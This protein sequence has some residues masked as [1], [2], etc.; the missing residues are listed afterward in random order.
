VG[1][2]R[3]VEM[4]L[5][6]MGWELG[7]DGWREPLNAEAPFVATAHIFPLGERKYRLAKV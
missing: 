5:N 3:Q 7:I 2:R 4:M 6:G 1:L